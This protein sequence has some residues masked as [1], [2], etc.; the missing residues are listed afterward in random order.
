M[1]G[2]VLRIKPVITAKDG[3]TALYARVA[4]RMERAVDRIVDEVQRTYKSGVVWVVEGIA[5]DL[6]E[7]LISG[8]RERVG[9]NREQILETRMT[10]T[11]MVHLGRRVVGV[12]WEE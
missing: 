2:T 8:L 3:A 10:S 1:L 12:V 7:L 5:P 4:G 6:R 11:F 9:L